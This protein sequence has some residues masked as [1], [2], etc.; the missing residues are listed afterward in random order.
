MDVRRGPCPVAREK[1]STRQESCAIGRSKWP[2]YRHGCPSSLR[3]KN[4]A[5]TKAGVGG[6]CVIAMGEGRRLGGA[7]RGELEVR[8]DIG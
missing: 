1:A 7:G 8:R 2:S 5:L 4:R 6:A 3:I